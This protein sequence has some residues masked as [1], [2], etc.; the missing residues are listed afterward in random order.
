MNWEAIGALA[1]LLA[2]VGGIAAVVYL[3]VQIRLN[4]RAVRSS[5]IDSWVTAIALGNDA[6]ASTDEFIDKATQKYDEL[7]QHQR[8]MYHRALAQNTNAMEALYFH[9]LNGVI[10][11]TFLKAKMKPIKSIFQSPGAS[12]WWSKKGVYMYDP[13]YVEYVENLFQPE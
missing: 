12:E 13:R 5:S 6:M 10:D 2:A 9:Y 11:E 8:I 3:A 4:T 7:N 1:E